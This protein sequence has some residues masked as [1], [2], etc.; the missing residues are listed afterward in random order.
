MRDVLDDEAIIEA[1]DEKDYNRRTNSH[2]SRGVQG[3]GIQWHLTVCMRWVCRGLSN[4]KSQL[5]P[6]PPKAGPAG[7][8]TLSHTLK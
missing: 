5:P 6:A 8:W 3:L 4:S 7:A 2:L 1:F